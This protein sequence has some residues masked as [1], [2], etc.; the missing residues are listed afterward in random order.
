ML[1]TSMMEKKLFVLL[2]QTIWKMCF[3]LRQSVDSSRHFP[4]WIWRKTKCNY[5]P[6]KCQQKLE[7]NPAKYL[8]QLARFSVF[9]T[10]KIF[11]LILFPIVSDHRK[12]RFTWVSM[13]NRFFW[14]NYFYNFTLSDEGLLGRGS[15]NSQLFWGI[16]VPV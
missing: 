8:L 7:K 9:K 14:T 5:L 3:F 16:W 12:F 6:I 2:S 11:L 13:R 4:Y 15:K 10:R 1:R